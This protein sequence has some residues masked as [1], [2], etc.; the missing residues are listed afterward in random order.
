VKALAPTYINVSTS[1]EKLMKNVF[2]MAILSIVATSAFAA[3]SPQSDCRVRVNGSE[4]GQVIR[5]SEFF[6][7]VANASY[8][9]GCSYGKVFYMNDSGRVYSGGRLVMDPQTGKRQDLSTKEAARAKRHAGGRCM[10]VS[11][12]EIV[13]VTSGSRE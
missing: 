3:N 13:I 11:C 12:D 4:T 6:S 1:K 5:S 2:T 8:E 9:T 10:E 7:A